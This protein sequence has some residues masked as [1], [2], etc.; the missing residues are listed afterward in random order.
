MTLV[1]EN[2]EPT[3]LVM[4]LAVLLPSGRAAIAAAKE[5][6]PLDQTSA[7]RQDLETP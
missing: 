7:E 3:V 1:Q 2:V 5:Q 4:T 6:K